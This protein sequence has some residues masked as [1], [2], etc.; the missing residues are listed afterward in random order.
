LYLGTQAILGRIWQQLWLCTAGVLFVVAIL[1][2][3]GTT[4]SIQLTELSHLPIR[5]GFST[6]VFLKF[7][8]LEMFYKRLVFG[9]LAPGLDLLL[10]EDWK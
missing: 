1:L 5:A 10:L 4:W 3:Q 8:Q 2:P 7:L 9:C 6:S